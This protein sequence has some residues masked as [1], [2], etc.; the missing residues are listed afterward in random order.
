MLDEE[1]ELLNF[2]EA[3]DHI[4]GSHVEEQYEEDAYKVLQQAKE[5]ASKAV[6]EF[7]EIPAH[8]RNEDDIEKYLAAIDFLVESGSM[9]LE[10]AKMLIHKAQEAEILTYEEE[11]P[12]EEPEEKVPQRK[13]FKYEKEIPE[14]KNKTKIVEYKGR[15]YHVLPRE[16]YRRHA[17][18]VL[19]YLQE[20]GTINVSTG[21]ILK[22]SKTHLDPKLR[23]N[24]DSES[25]SRYLVA[26]YETFAVLIKEKDVENQLA[27][28][29]KKEESLTQSGSGKSKKEAQSKS[30]K[31]KLTRIRKRIKECKKLLAMF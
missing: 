25:G 19:P 30:K 16:E 18:K 9:S 22:T 11:E 27:A 6:Q 2:D 7:A 3:K 24:K 12:E 26:F 4:I 8:K 17:K 29:Q 10:H 23:R 15:T 31:K 5:A 21:N 20:R 13:Q 14:L 1:V 28:L